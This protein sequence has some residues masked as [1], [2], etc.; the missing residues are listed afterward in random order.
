MKKMLTAALL[1]AAFAGQAL[2]G[3]KSTNPVVV[4][5]TTKT[6]YGSMGSAR[7]SADTTQF[8]GCELVGGP[9]GPTTVNCG[10]RNSAFQVVYCSSTDPAVV[11]MAYGLTANSYLYFRADANGRCSYLNIDN[12]SYEQPVTP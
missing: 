5:T 11:A 1:V 2:A 12:A 10:A 8:I 3:Y 6:A 4:N 9:G 7:A